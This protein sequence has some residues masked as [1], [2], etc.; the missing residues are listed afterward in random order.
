MTVLLIPSL[1][2]TSTTVPQQPRIF[3]LYLPWDDSTSS[4]IGLSKYLD[5]PAGR[6]GYVTV[7]DDGHL[8]VGEKRSKF[9]RD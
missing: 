3:E 4:K 2:A 5:K 6:Y 8:R 1:I 9:L 7:G